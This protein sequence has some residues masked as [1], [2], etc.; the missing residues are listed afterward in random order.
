MCI[1]DHIVLV[2]LRG[3][4]S[5]NCEVEGITGFLKNFMNENLENVVYTHH[6]CAHY[7]FS[8]FE[9]G[10]PLGNLYL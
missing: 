2:V 7:V 3:S 5:V 4:S 9:L 8:P 6:I 10:T 1:V